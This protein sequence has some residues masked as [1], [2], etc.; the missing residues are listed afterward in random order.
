[1]L[2]DPLSRGKKALGKKKRKESFI[3]RRYVA[4]DIEN[5]QTCELLKINKI[6]KRQNCLKISIE[7]NNI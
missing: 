6:S 7:K 4:L 1:V 5:S 3:Y 2:H